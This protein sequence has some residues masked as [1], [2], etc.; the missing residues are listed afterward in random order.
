MADHPA[1]KAFCARLGAFINGNS[2]ELADFTIVCGNREWNVHRLVLALHSDV[3][4]KSCA[5]SFKVWT[6]FCDH[7]RCR[8][9]RVQES[10]EK[11]I[12]LTD[13]S[14]SSRNVS[15]RLSLP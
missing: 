12:D 9:N 1:E 7:A 10:I 2:S 14:S 13:V 5:G 6:C 4:K 11:K 15:G 3:L 8:A